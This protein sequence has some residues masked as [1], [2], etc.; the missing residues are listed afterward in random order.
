[1]SMTRSYFIAADEVQWNYLPKGVDGI[2][3][4]NLN[5]TFYVQT[6][7]NRIGT[8]YSKCLYREYTDESFLKEKQ[9][10]DEWTHLG[11]LGPALRAQVGDMIRVTFLNRCSFPAS[12]HSHALSSFSAGEMNDGARQHNNGGSNNVDGSAVQPNSTFVYEWFVPERSGPA[13]KDGSSVVW[14]YHSHVDQVTDMNAGLIGSLIITRAGWSKSNMNLMPRDVDREFVVMFTVMDENRSHF[15]NASVINAIN[16][17]TSL[18]MLMMDEDFLRSN[19]KSTIN[20]RMFSNLDGIIMRTNEAVRWYIFAVG[21]ETD[22][23]GVHWHGQT[24]TN[25]GLRYTASLSTH[26]D[27][28]FIIV[29]GPR[30]CNYCLLVCRQWI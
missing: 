7:F 9:R 10:K 27:V 20:G 5:T 11:L 30:V 19:Q 15:L 24:V 12:I 13:I 1:M 4:R 6:T 17:S 23:H 22:L 14:M 26:I 28:S 21:D 8:T 2:T 18:G 29:V 25:K 16:S 3:G